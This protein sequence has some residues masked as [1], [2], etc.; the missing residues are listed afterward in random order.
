LELKA[1]SKLKNPSNL[2][3]LHKGPSTKLTPLKVAEIAMTRKY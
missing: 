3:L 2:I 1:E